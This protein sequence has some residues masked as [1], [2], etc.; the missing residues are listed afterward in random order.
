MR[1]KIKKK[2]DILIT[3]VSLEKAVEIYNEKIVKDFLEDEIPPL[4]VYEKAI[5]EGVLECFVYEEDEKEVGYIVTRKRDDLVFLLVLAINKDARGSGYGNKMLEEF[6]GNVRDSR[7]I[8][9]E[10]ENPEVKDIGDEEK[11]KREKRIKFY[12]KL[13][14]K[15]TKNLKYFLCGIDYKILYYNI[16]N[17]DEYNPKEVI[18][19]MSKIYDNL[20]RDK[21]KLIM[22]EN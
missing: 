22:E 7:V 20:L 11:L 3:K 6:K 21:T 18:D 8:L 10:A 16:E 19:C 4:F 5:K 13:G 14:F 1:T 17:D 9:L 2:G 12:E 15:V